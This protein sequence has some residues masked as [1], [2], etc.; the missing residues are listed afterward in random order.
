VAG[1][2]LRFLARKEIALRANYKLCLNIK[3]K[4]ITPAITNVDMGAN[5]VVNVNVNDDVV[6][7]V[8]TAS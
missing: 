8:A 6:A 4:T 1:H 7:A 3:R 5:V 2:G